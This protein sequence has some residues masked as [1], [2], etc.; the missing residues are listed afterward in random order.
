[1]YEADQPKSELLELRH[2]AQ[3][4]QRS[5]AGGTGK[6][7]LAQVDVNIT[8]SRVTFTVT[9]D[10]ADEAFQAAKLLEAVGCVCTSSGETQ[11]TCKCGS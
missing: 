4:L 11:V 5:M 9:G 8:A 10:T 1:M 2:A 3:S 7:P 6:P